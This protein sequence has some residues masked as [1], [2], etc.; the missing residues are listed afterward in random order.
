MEPSGAGG[1]GP[2]KTRRN[3]SAKAALVYSIRALWT[4]RPHPQVSPE[5]KERLTRKRRKPSATATR[6]AA[7]QSAR[8]G[9]EIVDD[10]PGARIS[11]PAPISSTCDA[12]TGM[13]ATERD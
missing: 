5:R 8:M 2:Q 9:G 7:R 11:R 1:T 13:L 4:T 3:G 12:K 6:T 10:V